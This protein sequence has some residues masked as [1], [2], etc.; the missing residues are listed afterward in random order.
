MYAYRL[1]STRFLAPTALP[2][3]VP[4]IQK[5]M[6]SF[7]GPPVAGAR[8]AIAD[9]NKTKFFRQAILQRV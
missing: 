1:T 2:V 6:I 9:I 5:L 7:R 8:A 3:S 4:T